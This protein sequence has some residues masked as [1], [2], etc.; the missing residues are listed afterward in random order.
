MII[1]IDI[2]NSFN[3][4][5]RVVTLDVLSGRVS[6]DYACDLK[7]GDVIPTY[8]N[9]SNLFGYFK[10]MYTCHTILRYFD[11]NGQVHLVKDKTDGQHGDPLE[12]LI[13]NLTIHNLW[14]HVLT[15]FLGGGSGGC[16]FRRRIHQR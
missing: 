12:M 5:C 9:L 13:F 16:V 3:S 11:W 4:A 10:V 1:K 6:C 2:S 14:G 15:K 8:E 7:K